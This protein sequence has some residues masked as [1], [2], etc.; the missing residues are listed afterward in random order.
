MSR[1]QDKNNAYQKTKKKKKK[2]LQFEEKEKIS[3]PDMAR[4][5]ELW[6]WEFKTTMTNTLRALKGNSER[7]GNTRPPD[8]PL[9]KPVCRSGSNS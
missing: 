3:E 2:T 9:K 4:I 1:H 7:D 5:L 8:L 6:D